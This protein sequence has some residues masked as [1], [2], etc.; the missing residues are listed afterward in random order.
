M[1]ILSRPMSGES[2]RTPEE[3]V[4]LGG[5][6]QDASDTGRLSALFG[7]ALNAAMLFGIYS[8]ANLVSVP[9]RLSTAALAR[10]GL[11]ILAYLAIFPTE[12]RASMGAT[13]L[14]LGLYLV[15][16]GVGIVAKGRISPIGLS[17]TFF[18]ALG[19]ALAAILLWEAGFFDKMLLR[20]QYDYGSALTRDYAMDILQSISDFALWFGLSQSRAQHHPGGVRF[21]C[22]R[23]FLGQFHLC[24]RPHHHNS[25]VRDTLPVFVPQSSQILLLRHLLRLHAHIGEHFRLQ[26]NLEQ[27]HDTHQQP[28]R[29]NI[30]LAAGRSSRATYCHCPQ[31][32]EDL[33]TTGAIHWPAC[34]NYVKN[35]SRYREMQSLLWAVMKRME[36]WCTRTWQ[37]DPVALRYL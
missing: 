29:R 30:H 24:W 9:M 8:I 34:L 37:I 33:P 27:D 13:T 31:R 36:R 17:L 15:C 32:H 28:D 6:L 4:V 12:S 2:I 19:F 1:W 21:N 25:A 5:Q 3:L 26:L 22:Y 16:F 7:H 18:I 20:F 14:I 35:F 10:L 23:N 11:S